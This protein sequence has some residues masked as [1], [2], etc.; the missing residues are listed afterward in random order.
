M[1]VQDQT[2]NVFCMN[3]VKNSLWTMG[4]FLDIA[5]WGVKMPECPV[6]MREDCNDGPHA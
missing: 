5:F 3:H 4:Q 6:M 2:R 1:E